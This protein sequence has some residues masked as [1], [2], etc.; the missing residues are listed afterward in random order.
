MTN[1]A[2]YAFCRD[3]RKTEADPHKKE[4]LSDIYKFMWECG[5]SKQ[6]VRDFTNRMIAEPKNALK[7][8]AYTWLLGV[9]GV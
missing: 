2:F 6:G 4:A 5:I 3:Q 8:E 9:F 1:K 7:V